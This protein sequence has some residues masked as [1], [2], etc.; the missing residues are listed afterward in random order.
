[1]IKQDHFFKR[2]GPHLL[3]THLTYSETHSKT[4]LITDQDLKFSGFWRLGGQNTRK[5]D[6]F[7]MKF[8]LARFKS[9]VKP[10]CHH[11]RNIQRQQKNISRSP[12]FHF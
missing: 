12:E 8:H 1:M 2:T 4:V 6:I 3:K 7:Q 5:N 10:F 11:I 9:T